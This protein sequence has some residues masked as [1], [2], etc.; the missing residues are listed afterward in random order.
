MYS[1]VPYFIFLLESTSV[2]CSTSRSFK[3]DHCLTYSSLQMYHILLTT[4]RC[5]SSVKYFA[6]WQFT[7]V[8]FHHWSLEQQFQARVES[9]KYSMSLSPGQVFLFVSLPAKFPREMVELFCRKSDASIFPNT[10]YFTDLAIFVLRPGFK[11]KN[12]DN[13]WLCEKSKIFMDS[14]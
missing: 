14:F 5:K 9:F 2:K 13:S 1:S 3:L 10:S 7:S 11:N 8:D 6:C 4:H 12:D